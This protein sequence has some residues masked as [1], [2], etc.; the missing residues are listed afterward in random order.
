MMAS[1][2]DMVYGRSDGIGEYVEGGARSK[3]M[4]KRDDGG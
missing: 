4:T 3:V 2:E 1:A